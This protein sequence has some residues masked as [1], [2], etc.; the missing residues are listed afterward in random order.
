[1]QA[2]AHRCRGR[3]LRVEGP[4]RHPMRALTFRRPAYAAAL[5][6]L[7]LIAWAP[8]AARAA[9]AVPSPAPSPA[10]DTPADPCGGPG[11]L[12]ATLNRPTVGYSACAIEAGTAVFEIGYQNQVTGQGANA[13]TLAEYPQGF[14]RFGLR[15]RFEF[16]IIGP[17]DA[18]SRVPLGN[19]LDTVTNG[20]YDSGIGFKYELPP[21][22][23]Y[24]I[25]I[26]G[27]YTS[28][29]GSPAFTAGNAT[30]TGNIDIAYALDA[31]T[32]IG[33]TLAFSTTGG[34]AAN[35]SHARYGTFMPSLV[36][37]KQLP[38]AYQLYAEYVHLSKTA[39]DQGQRNFVDYGVQKLLGT[40][41]E[42]DVELGDSITPN[43]ARRFNY[44]G[45]GLGVQLR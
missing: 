39:P 43:A 36:V 10:A 42:I 35:G 8:P 18:R 2:A 6:T 40:R 34:Y 19:G 11:A 28:P 23:R 26:D 22:G 33:T 16:D 38:D 41:T 12:L 1:M 21:G 17:S 44:V 32:G 3:G 25:G 24:T 31:T 27:L 29:N 45:F 9:S 7:C 14:I 20:A 37:T 13:Q 5:A 30:L 15:P 4:K